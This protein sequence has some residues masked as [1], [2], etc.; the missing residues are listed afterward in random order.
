MESY[1]EQKNKFKDILPEKTV[2]TLVPQVKVER[3]IKP[4]PS[5]YRN[6]ISK[7][8]IRRSSDC[9]RCGKCVEL[10]PY[11]VHVDKPG[12]KYFAEPKLNLCIGPICEKTDHY[13]ITQ[14]PQSAL[15]MMENPMMKAIGDYR[16]TSDMILATWR[17]AETGDIPAPEYGYDY[18]CGNSGGGFDKIR[19]KFPDR[20]SV[21]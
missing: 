11:G 12:Y 13:C 10:C 9:V 8:I 3:T 2:K 1:L 21:V 16:W 7:Y 19:F 6:E 15:S 18:H 14:C 4:A 5:R 17:M 20:K